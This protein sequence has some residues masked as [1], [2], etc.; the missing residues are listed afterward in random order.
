[1]IQLYLDIVLATV[2]DERDYQTGLLDTVRDD[3]RD[4]LPFR[5]HAVHL[6]VVESF[7]IPVVQ[8]VI[9]PIAR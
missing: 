7:V 2:I 9:F 8:P 5:D 1:M 4:A 6:D 3:L